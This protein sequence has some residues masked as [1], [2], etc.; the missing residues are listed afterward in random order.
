MFTIRHYFSN[1]FL[2]LRQNF[3]LGGPMLPMFYLKKERKS[4]RVPTLIWVYLV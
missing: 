2:L 1:F 3:R 4:S